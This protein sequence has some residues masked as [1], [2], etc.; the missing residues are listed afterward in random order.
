MRSLGGLLRW[1]RTDILRTNRSSSWTATVLGTIMPEECHGQHQEFANAL[2]RST[3]TKGM[4][5]ALM[6]QLFLL[7]NNFT[8]HEG[9]YDVPIEK[10]AEIHDKRVLELFR[11]S[12]MG[13]LEQ[14][15]RLDLVQGTII[16]AITDQLFASALRLGEV[17]LLRSMLDFGVNVDMPIDGLYTTMSP[18]EFA[19]SIKD[20]RL[21]FKIAQLLL[22]HKQKPRINDEDGVSGSYALVLTFGSK[23][24]ELAEDLI[25]NGARASSQCLQLALKTGD[26]KW[27]QLALDA[28]ADVHA[29]LHVID[30]EENKRWQWTAIGY[31]VSLENN[32]E[33]AE[34]LLDHPG[35]DINTPQI[36]TDDGGPK[37]TTALGLAAFYGDLT[38]TEFLLLRG[39]A[40]NLAV[41]SSMFPLVLACRGGNSEI[42]RTL[43][44]A[45]ADV[46]LAD[47]NAAVGRDF[48][49]GSL[50][51]T[52][53]SFCKDTS[54]V[55][56][57]SEVLAKGAPISSNAFRLAI[58]GGRV[59]IARM[60]Y[61]AQ[62]TLTE[63][64]NGIGS[65]EMAHFLENAG[66]LPGI[67]HNDGPRLLSAAIL[68]E[69]RDLTALLLGHSIDVTQRYWLSKNPDIPTPLDAAVSRGNIELAKCFIDSGAFVTENT[70]NAAVWGSLRTGKSNILQHCLELARHAGP[71][72]L[73]PGA[74]GCTAVNM[75]VLETNHGIVRILLDAGIDP[76]GCPKI[77]SC[78]VNMGKSLHWWISDPEDPTG[79]VL[80][81]ALEEIEE[82]EDVD[83]FRMLLGATAWDRDDTGC[84][85]AAAICYGH[86]TL[87]RDL[88]NVGAAVNIEYEY[89]GTEMTALEAAVD[90]QQVQLV[91]DL[92]Q[93]G[94]DVNQTASGDESRTALQRAVGMGHLELIE[95]LL[96]MGAD[97]NVPAAY[98]KGATALQIAAIQGYLGIAQRL[99]EKGADPNAARA[100]FK[101]RTALAGAAE[102]GRLEMLHLL[103]Q[104]GARIDDPYRMNYIIAV[105]LAERNGRSGAVKLLKSYGGWT[106]SDD[107]EYNWDCDED[108]NTEDMEEDESDLDLSEHQREECN[109]Y[110]PV[111]GQEDSTEINDDVVME[112]QGCCSEIN[113]KS[114]EVDQED[115]GDSERPL[116]PTE[117]EMD[118]EWLMK[119]WEWDAARPQRQ[120][121][122]E[123]WGVW[124]VTGCN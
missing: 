32:I 28:G 107:A 44:N 100:A 69:D 47:A 108:D 16:A 17:A 76:R 94:A 101:G 111:E 106:D 33:L 65:M 115:Q 43:L 39:A 105:R 117:V 77:K 84:A 80:V 72:G 27:L 96:E 12:G 62:A 85:L 118:F 99:L 45:G 40:V 58:E 98:N 86:Y 87:A 19:A 54:G 15:K 121:D 53:T 64:I 68:A 55:E 26:K 51:G 83:M 37:W 20:H 23:H 71:G 66:I 3:D 35:S 29:P 1:N 75:A 59:E 103:L 41:D 48:S 89:R 50:L 102:N 81:T 46:L 109:E 7:S 52:I 8:F 11:E 122:S 9:F 4:T 61:S 22:S 88:M 6:I 60:L 25:N 24:R 110:A 10:L 90:D 97:V 42:A 73:F 116:R 63:S 13:G 36:Y 38:M 119:T 123:G 18:L 31:L 113:G 91:R 104:G 95:I 49:S 5:E 21:S 79:S 92:F 112:D 82:E 78:C 70:L 2:C 74:S 56:L 30:S 124:D 57:C 34:T 120:G 93:A 114:N 14:L 67:I